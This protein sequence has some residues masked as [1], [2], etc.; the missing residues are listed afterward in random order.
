ML[1]NGVRYD[2]LPVIHIQSTKNNTIMI[3]TDHTGVYSCHCSDI[4]AF[5]IECSAKN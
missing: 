5:D 2:E 3:V 1:V 4:L